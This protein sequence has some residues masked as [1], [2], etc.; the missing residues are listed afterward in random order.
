VSNTLEVSMLESIKA[1]N[2]RGWSNRRIAKELGIHRQ[3][4]RKCLEAESKCTISTAGCPEPPSAKCTISTV[5]CAAS[6]SAECTISTAGEFEALRT[7]CATL[8]VGAVGRKSLCSGHA[9]TI[10]EA[11]EAGLSAQRIFQDLQSNSGFAG[12][13]ESVKRYARGIEQEIGLPFRRMEA[14]PGAECQVDYGIGAWIV[15]EGGKRRKTHLFRITLSF[16]RKGYSEVTFTQATDS[17]LRSLE[18]AFRTFG[19]VP[20]TVVIDNLK[21]GV[22]KAD[23]YDPDLNPKLRDFAQHYGTC[24]M[25]CRVRTPRHKGKVERQ[26]GYVQDNALK[27]RTF[28][29][30]GEEN[31]FLRTWE[32]DVADKRIHGTVRRQVCTMYEEERVY[33][34]PLPPGLFPAFK[35]AVRK[36]HR[37]GHVEV[38][39]AYYSV[40]PEYVQRQVWV[41]YDART[42]CVL[43]HRMEQITVHAR[44]QPGQ[45]STCAE[46]IPKEKMGNP[47]RG[48]EWMLRKAARIGEA[49]HAWAFAMLQNRGIAGT[50]VLNGLL[51][52]TDKYPA[53]AINQGCLRALDGGFFSMHE[54]KDHII[55]A[56]DNEQQTF[57]FIQIHPLIRDMH[58]YEQTIK[59][60]ELFT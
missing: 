4:V 41:R 56:H 49:A 59:T 46:H 18:N 10:K 42:V 38:E 26:V 20:Q 1:L 3:S 14:L 11:L 24:I 48:N 34:K 9:G 6:P 47:E 52:L 54:L 44:K 40:P 33:L 39:H 37:D 17:F 51:G 22:L 21:A 28:E 55:H 15:G 8:T 35:E 36:V 25:P 12:S 13:Y 57:D 32:R 30:L 43:N 60:K 29:T 19:G 16:S 31:L 58:E 27:G 2:A 45:F 7:G 23:V 50:R 5:G 53:G